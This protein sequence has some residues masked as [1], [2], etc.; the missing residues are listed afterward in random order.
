[1]FTYIFFVLQA[2]NDYYMFQA[3]QIDIS[4]G[5]PEMTKPV[6]LGS[7]QRQTL[8]IP[9][10]LSDELQMVS[11]MHRILKINTHAVFQWLN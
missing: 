8:L 9:S 5:N 2:S 7:G 4:F 1:M 10:T 6:T 11:E 3:G